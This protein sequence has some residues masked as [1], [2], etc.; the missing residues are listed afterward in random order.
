MVRNAEKK[1]PQ[2]AQPNDSRI[3]RIGKVLRKLYLDE[4]PQFYNIFKGDISFVGPRPERPEFVEQLKKEI[5]YYEI[6]HLIK[7]GFTGW[8]QINYY[9]GASIEEAKEKLKYELYYVKNRS[10]FL[11]LGIILK[12]IQIIFK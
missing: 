6:R 11:D 5:P 1:G 7:P 3:T 2:W 8:A 10:F 9:Y 12:T 4:F